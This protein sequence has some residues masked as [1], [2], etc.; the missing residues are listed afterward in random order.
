[1]RERLVQKIEKDT[2]KIGSPLVVEEEERILSF[3]NVTFPYLK[4][5]AQ[6]AFKPTTKSKRT[7]LRT[8]GTG[9]SQYAKFLLSAPLYSLVCS[10][11]S[12]MPTAG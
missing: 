7:L 9:E 2:G 5:G 1:M 12:S 10:F 6:F 8:R 4:F 3:L 11:P